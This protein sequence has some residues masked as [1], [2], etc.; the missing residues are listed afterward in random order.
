MGQL[1]REGALKEW[2]G[3]LEE[4]D[5]EPGGRDGVMVQELGGGLV[6]GGA[7]MVQGGGG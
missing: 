3:A 4:L 7:Q 6:L 1:V 5:G 2:G